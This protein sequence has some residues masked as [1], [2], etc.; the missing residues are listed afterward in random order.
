MSLT[1][2]LVLLQGRCGGKPELK[3]TQSGTAFCR[4]SI[5]TEY[6]LKVDGEWEKRTDWHNVVFFGNTAEFVAKHCD[7]GTAI[8]IS[9]RLSYSKYEKGGNTIYRTDIIGNEVHTLVAAGGG[10]QKRYGGNGITALPEDE[11]PPDD[12]PF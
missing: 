11:R 1:Q 6:S 10:G 7:K 4:V 3:T 5:A 8:G 12:I 2:N 9:G